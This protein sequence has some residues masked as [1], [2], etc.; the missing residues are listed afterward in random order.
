LNT[1]A[2]LLA[3]LVFNSSLDISL[4]NPHANA[5]GSEECGIRFA[6]HVART[7]IATSSPIAD[8]IL[9]SHGFIKLPRRKQPVVNVTFTHI[10]ASSWKT[11]EEIF[12]YS[13]IFQAG[14]DWWL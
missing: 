2:S 3:E 4:T 8:L 6:V 14:N 12:I 11:E 13:R 9:E 7:G 1:S 5:R 10:V